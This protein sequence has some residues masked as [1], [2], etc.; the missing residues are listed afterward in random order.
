MR[1]DLLEW[2][3]AEPLVEGTARSLTCSTRSLRGLPEVAACFMSE[4]MSERT[5]D[6]PIP[7]LDY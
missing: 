5:I 2:P 3:E 1:L 4:R 7:R 6:E